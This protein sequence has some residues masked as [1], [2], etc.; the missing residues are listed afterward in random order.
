M[1]LW[2][3][4]RRRRNACSRSEVPDLDSLVVRDREELI[5]GV[6]DQAEVNVGLPGSGVEDGRVSG[7]T[8]I[9]ERNAERLPHDPRV[10]RWGR[11]SLDG[12]YT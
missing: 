8:C 7:G 6:V 3:G 1:R 9:F 2:R 12:K 10:L 11:A 4:R 5:R